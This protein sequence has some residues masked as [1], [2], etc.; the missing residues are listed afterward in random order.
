[1]MDVSIV[2]LNWNG[3]EDTIACLRPMLDWRQVRPFLIVVD[4]AST[5]DDVAQIRQALPGVQLI[6]NATNEGFSG[7]SNGGIEFA[8]A[9]GDAP[10]LLLN[11]DAMIAET[12]VHRLCQTL[13]ENPQIGMVVPQLL[14]EH[15]ELVAVGG[16]NPAFHL[17]TR[18]QSFPNE[19]PVQ[20]VETV[21]GTAV[22][23]CAAML[24]QV[25][26]LDERYFFSTEMAD[27]ALRARQHG[28]V[29]AV[30]RRAEARHT[31]SRSAP[32]RNSLYVYYIVRNRL[33][34]LRS[35]YR[36]R[37]GLR[38]FWLAYT[39]VLALKLRLGGQRVTARAV[40]LALVDGVNGRFGGQNER[41]LAY[42]TGKVAT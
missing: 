12:A 31:I 16:K 35:H 37:L 1:M 17:Q 11:N 19:A 23:I 10:I 14:N 22:L 32:L 8:L 28:F 42:C 24:R 40:W 34:F 4:N 5:G 21:S 6:E 3:A 38:A 7:G 36:W 9:Q 27:L 33:L 41:V 15:G 20:V 30:D 18:V 29:C 13:D 25:G 2:L 39:L 26:L